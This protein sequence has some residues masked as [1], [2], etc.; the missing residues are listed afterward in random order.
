[1]YR[2]KTS[3]KASRTAWLCELSPAYDPWTDFDSCALLHR[4]RPDLLNF[5]ELDK[6]DPRGNTEKAFAIAEAHLGIPVSS[7]YRLRTPK[8]QLA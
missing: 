5:E 2:S 4:H 3:R 7:A 1:M 8:T 6:A